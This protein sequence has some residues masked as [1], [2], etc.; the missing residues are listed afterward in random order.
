MTSSIERHWQALVAPAE[1][2]E[3]QTTCL[4]AVA[5]P[6]GILTIAAVGDGMVLVRRADGRTE[7]VVGPRGASFGGDTEALGGTHTWRECSLEWAPGDVAVIATDG[8]TDDVLA[9]RA[10][11]LVDWL[12]ARFADLPARSRWRALARDLNAWPTP[13]HRDDKTLVVLMAHSQADA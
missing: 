2:R 7:W 10:G 3:C 8:V 9:E 5:R 6:E 11:D 13:G 12:V 1:P 4:V